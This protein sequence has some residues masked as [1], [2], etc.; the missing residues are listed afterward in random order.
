MTLKIFLASLFGFCA[1]AACAPSANEAAKETME[2]EKTTADEDAA[3]TE[4]STPAAEDSCNAAEY[5]SL[6]G[7]NIAAVTL[8][9]DL[10]HRV[11]GP[12]DAAT[13]DYRSGRL[14][15]MTDDDGVIFEVKCG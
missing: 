3:P 10:F 1:L 8:P 5:Q 7:A 13:M 9:A 14:N 4:P 6:V 2:A 15:L 12:N 11:L